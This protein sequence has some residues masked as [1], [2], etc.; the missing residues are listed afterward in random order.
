M[1]GK[2]STPLKEFFGHGVE[3]L[4]KFFKNRVAFQFSGIEIA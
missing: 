3:F 4:M 1:V 2:K